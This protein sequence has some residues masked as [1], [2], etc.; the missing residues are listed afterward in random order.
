MNQFGGKPALDDLLEF[1]DDFDERTRIKGDAYFRKGA[2]LGIDSHDNGKTYL[3]N[4]VGSFHYEVTL[5]HT[6]E[7]WEG[8]CTCPVE[9][10][11]KHVFAA[12]KAL[13]AQYTSDEVRALASLERIP[14]RTAKSKTTVTKNGDTLAQLAILALGRNLTRGEHDICSRIRSTYKNCALRQEITSWDFH[15]MGFASPG[16]PYGTLDIWPKFP[17]S[18]REFWLYVAYALQKAGVNYPKFLKPVTDFKKI[19]KRMAEWQREREVERWKDQLEEFKTADGPAGQM[20]IPEYELRL[21]IQTAA[22][23]VEW[24]SPQ[25]Q[26]FERVKQNQWQNLRDQ[27]PSGKARLAVASQALFQCFEKRETF[28]PNPGTLKFDSPEERKLL[29]VVLR[30]PG[31]EVC[32]VNEAGQPLRRETQSLRWKLAPPENPD[33]NYRF[34]L[35]TADGTPAP[36]IL[37]TLSGSPPL[38]VTTDAIHPG[39]PL[40]NLLTPGTDN[41]IPMKALETSAGSQFLQRVGIELHPSLRERVKEVGYEV[42]IECKLAGIYPNSST[43]D[44]LFNVR[45]KSLDNEQELI[46]RDSLWQEEGVNVYGYSS[47]KRNKKPDALVVYNHRLLDVAAATLVPLGLKRSYNGA[48]ALRVNKHF[49][50]TF[51]SWLK[52]VP[53]EIHIALKGELASFMRDTIAGRVRLDVTEA[54]IDWFDL[55]VCWTLPTRC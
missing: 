13:L 38:Y 24:K 6:K 41:H 20:E 5:A 27:L 44:C 2:V 4:V 48:P 25:A 49:P 46:W 34:H 54:D 30:T 7:G 11:C 39:P 26:E 55:R 15:Q 1:I 18:E 50:D 19:E 12:A 47:K 28:S 23:V 16:I 8:D 45:A 33:G 42:T 35:I 9:Y 53:P 10:D 40:T 32:T 36:R 3:A 22:A 43:E 14:K 17:T 37:T 31:L 52:S 29:S 51:A 21:V